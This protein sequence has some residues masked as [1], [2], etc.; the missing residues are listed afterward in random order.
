MLR[1]IHLL[2]LTTNAYIATCSR[3]HFDSDENLGSEIDT[4][5]LT[6][7]KIICSYG[8]FPDSIN[9]LAQTTPSPYWILFEQRVDNV[10]K[11]IQTYMIE[12]YVM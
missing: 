12:L 2:L 3:E 1:I 10:I 7:K 8:L 9:S 6:T 5:M 11:G 4:S